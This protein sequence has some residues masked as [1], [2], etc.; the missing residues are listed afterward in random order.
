VRAAL[1]T[2]SLQVLQRR[3][4]DRTL[5][6]DLARLPL[7]PEQIVDT[8]A[9]H[10][11]TADG[12][13]GPTLLQTA[14]RG[15]RVDGGTEIPTTRLDGVILAP[16]LRA[17]AEQ[18][19]AA[20]R[21]WKR[22]RRMLAGTPHEGYG[23]APVLL[24]TGPPGTGKTR[25]AEAF[26]GELARPLRRLSGPDLR[27]CWY[28]EAEKTI[29]REFQRPGRSV[30][31]LDEVDAF[32]RTRG[33]GPQAHTDD[34]LANVLLEEIE[35]TDHAVLMAT[36]LPDALDPALARRVLF[37]LRFE[38]PGPQERAALWRLHLPA[39][40][41]GA[42]AVDCDRLAGL[43]LTGGDIKNASW[44]AL[45]AANR[46]DEPLTTEAVEAEARRELGRRT[47]RRTAG[48]GPRRD[49]G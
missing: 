28:G 29:R 21:D 13:D 12:V 36:N 2:R 18:A 17:D 39:R 37:H 8:A 43:A 14:G 9:R 7:H 3:A 35:R 31:F 23:H 34:R 48:F 40:I 30:L 24:F 46:R 25:L 19:L 5:V 32:L 15:V 6:D 16:S 44:R 45:L 26:A 4:L 33:G 22:L 1:W 20:C 49:R 47:S 38:P 10:A 27:S 11:M 41:A 42:D